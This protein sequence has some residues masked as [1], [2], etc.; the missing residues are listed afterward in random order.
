MNDSNTALCTLLCQKFSEI[1]TLERFS[2][3]HCQALC[4]HSRARE[5]TG[6]YFNY[7]PGPSI[8][9]VYCNAAI[10]H[11]VQNC[12]TVNLFLGMKGGSL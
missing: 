4:C 3:V 9:S 8:K 10:I 1:N 11:E 5:L 12:T 2:Y 6:S 7:Q